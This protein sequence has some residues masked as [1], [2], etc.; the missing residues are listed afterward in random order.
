MTIVSIVITS[1]NKAPYLEQAV[2]SVLAQTYYNIECIIV[3]VGSTDNTEKNS[4][5]IDCEI[6]AN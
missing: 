1:Y 6:Y 5:R 4:S 2:K 3:D